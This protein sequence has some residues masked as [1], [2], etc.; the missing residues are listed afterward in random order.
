MQG[1]NDFFSTSPYLKTRASPLQIALVIKCMG[2]IF[3]L[4]TEKNACYNFSE[5]F[6]T[7]S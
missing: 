6:V 2:L 4:I 5:S 7:N 1:G 3:I